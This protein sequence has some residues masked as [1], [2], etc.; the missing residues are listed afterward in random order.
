M[1]EGSWLENTFHPRNQQL[2]RQGYKTSD[3]ERGGKEWSYS[4]KPENRTN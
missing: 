2:K 4:V 3:A 1:I